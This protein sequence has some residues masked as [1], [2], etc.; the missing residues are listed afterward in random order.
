MQATENCDPFSAT[1]FSARSGP[2][3]STLK[4][5]ASCVRTLR[6]FT[7]IPMAPGFVRAATNRFTAPTCFQPGTKGVLSA[8]CAERKLGLFSAEKMRPAC[9]RPARRRCE[10]ADDAGERA[11]SGGPR[12][13][14]APHPFSCCWVLQVH[15]ANPLAHSHTVVPVEPYMAGHD[16]GSA[17]TSLRPTTTTCPPPVVADEVSACSGHG[18]TATAGKRQLTPDV[19]AGGV[20]EAAPRAGP[21]ATAA[22]SGQP[23]Q[24]KPARSQ[25]SIQ[26]GGTPV[27][28][29]LP[30]ICMTM[31]L[32]HPSDAII[33]H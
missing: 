13:K 9:A 22:V 18:A 32:G 6:R 31:I 28:L 21:T 14:F 3:A 30:I 16:P 29:H 5:T 24:E 11:L 15:A 23:W 33:T 25:G 27:L 17:S 26:V 4:W 8:S 19:S 12:P 20:Q 1:C 2:E 7:A 10:N